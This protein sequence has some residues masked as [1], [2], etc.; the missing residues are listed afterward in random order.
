MAI[1]NSFASRH[2]SASLEL[3]ARILSRT[4]R[5]MATGHE[6][7]RSLSEPQRTAL[8]CIIY[9]KLYHFR[10]SHTTFHNLLNGCALGSCKAQCLLQPL[11]L[12]AS[13]HTSIFWYFKPLLLVTVRLL[14]PN[15]CLR[16]AASWYPLGSHNILDQPGTG[17]TYSKKSRSEKL[18][19]SP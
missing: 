8:I 5:A 13:V 18:P 16:Q 9:C 17:S 1:F 19:L 15:E 4:S 14:D 11:I 2:D 10:N 3:V 6:L 12:K 7:P